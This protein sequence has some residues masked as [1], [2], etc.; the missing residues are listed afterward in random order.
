MSIPLKIHSAGAGPLTEDKILYVRLNPLYCLLGLEKGRNLCQLWLWV[1]ASGRLHTPSRPRRG[2][3]CTWAPGGGGAVAPRARGW[4]WERRH[5]VGPRPEGRS[6]QLLCCGVT[7]PGTLHS[8][9]PER[10]TVISCHL[11]SS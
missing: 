11:V 10:V 6:C 4:G 8:L 9:W 3:A 1:G 2:A 5:R 7:S